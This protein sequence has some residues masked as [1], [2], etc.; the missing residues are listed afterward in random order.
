MLLTQ[1]HQNRTGGMKMRMPY[2]MCHNFIANNSY[3]N[4]VMRQKKTGAITETNKR[5]RKKQYSLAHNFCF[6]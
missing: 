1:F 3:R 6:S 5:P 2:M 4:M